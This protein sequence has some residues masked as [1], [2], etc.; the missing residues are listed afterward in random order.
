MRVLHPV[1]VTFETQPVRVRLFLARPPT[2]T[3]RTGRAGRERGIELGFPGFAASHG[4]P[5]E[6]LGAVVRLP[7]E[8]VVDLHDRR[9]PSG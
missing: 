9:V 4:A 6:R 8:L 3:D 5:D 1:E 2:C 7:H